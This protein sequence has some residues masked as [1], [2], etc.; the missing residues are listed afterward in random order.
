M[1][2]LGVRNLSEMLH[3]AFLAELDSA[4]LDDES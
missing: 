1:R 3:L 4:D 2:K